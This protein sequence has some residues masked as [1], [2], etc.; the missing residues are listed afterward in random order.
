MGHW[1]YVP[2]QKLALPHSRNLVNIQKCSRDA[3][4]HLHKRRLRCDQA[5]LYHGEEEDEEYEEEEEEEEEEEIFS[6]FSSPAPPF[7]LPPYL[8]PQAQQQRA[9]ELSTELSEI[10][11]SH[12]KQMSQLT[13]STS[14]QMAQATHANQELRSRNEFLE[15]QL[16]KAKYVLKNL[17][18]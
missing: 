15:R 18:I 5:F 14:V 7:I 11:E 10:Q 4:Q 8:V 17:N 6:S 1:P 2:R 12:A 16:E 13:R 3:V 9:V